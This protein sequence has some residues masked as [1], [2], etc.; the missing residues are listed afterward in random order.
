MRLAMSDP[1]KPAVS[2]LI[3]DDNPG[4][5]EMLSSA[6]AQPGLEILT[7][8]DPEQGLELVHQ[9][10]PQIVLTDLVMPHLTGVEVLERIIEFDPSIDVILM[11]AHYSTESAVEAIKKGATDY[12]NKPISIA[13]LR[14]RVGKLVEEARR[15]QHALRL[16]DELLASSEFEGIIGRSPLMWNL[17]SQIRRVAPHY[18]SLLVTGPTGAGKDLI[19]QAIHK[20]SPAHTGRYAV[21]NCSAVVETLF[22][23]ELFGHVRGS[24]TGAT[25]DKPGMFEHA[26]GGTLFLDEIGDMPLNTQA[27][28]LRV[29]QNQEVQRV[30]SL[31]TRKVDVRV[32]AATN[33]DLRASIRDKTFREDLY[34]RLSMVELRVPPLA[35][36][37]EDLPLLERHLIAKFASQYKK[38]IRGLTHRAQILLALHSWP[39]NVRELENVLGHAA[40]MTL[41]DMIDVQDL[42]P[43][44]SS[45]AGRVS[46]QESPEAFS[47][48]EQGGTLEEQER[49]LIVRAMEAA[50]GNQSQAARALRIGRD[51]LRYKL[52]KHNLEPTH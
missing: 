11:T 7:S 22:E 15:R 9:H 52:K 10:R 18:R 42:P 27:K 32:I 50:G 4:S 16:E 46:G 39:G 20:R 24:F 36:R 23:S 40:M 37:R 26:H 33:H 5:L 48:T 51:A 25:A 8:S 43:Y 14:E 12:L 47:S 28:L 49:V 2:L 6:L 44:M 29:L 35:E 1:R 38:D 41:G 13:T 19:A 45:E 34:Y 21:L 30:G 17:F 31:S 3:I